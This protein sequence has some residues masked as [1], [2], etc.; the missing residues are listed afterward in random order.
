MRLHRLAILALLGLLA[1]CVDDVATGGPTLT[2]NDVSSDGSNGGAVGDAAGG[3]DGTGADDLGSGGDSVEPAD[4]AIGSDT[5]TGSGD[6]IEDDA[7]GTPDV[8]DTDT[9]GTP[10]VID[11]DTPG[12]P[13]VVDTDTPGTPDVVDTDTPGTPDVVDNDTP[14]TPDV[15]DNDTPGTPDVIEDDTTGTPDVIEQDS[16]TGG[17]TATDQDADQ[18][19]GTPG[20]V[21]TKPSTEVC[22]GIDNDCNG[23]TDEATCADGSCTTG[24]CSPSK[25]AP[26]GF[27]CVYAPKAGACDDGDACTLGDTCQG[28]ICA[29][30]AAKECDDGNACTADTCG[31]GV[32][33]HVAVPG[34]SGGTCLYGKQQCLKGSFCAM[35]EGVCA[36]EGT[37]AP[38]PVD[39]PKNY[40]PVCGCNGKTYQNSCAASAS[41]VGVASK[42]AC[43]IACAVGDASVCGTTSYCQGACGGKGICEARPTV[44]TKELA[45]VCG[46]DGKTYQNACFAKMAGVAKA[47]DGACAPPGCKS[48]TDCDDGKPCTLD[49]C[50]LATGKC[51]HTAIA[52][53]S[54]SCAQGQSCDDG[55]VCTS[56]TC[57]KLGVCLHGAIDGICDDGNACTHKDYCKGGQCVAGV[58]KAC[59]DGN[60]CT[61]D[62]CDAST[63]LCVYKP[64]AGCTGNKCTIGDNT[65]CTKGAWCEATTVG[66]CS[67]GGVCSTSPTI[68]PLAVVPVCGCDAKTYNNACEAAKAGVNVASQGPCFKPECATNADCNDGD[69][70]T[71]DACSAGKCTHTAIKGCKKCAF[72][73]QCDDGNICTTDACSQGICV[74]ATI[75]GCKACKSGAECS[76]GQNCTYD[77]CVGG[78]C[79]HQQI[80]GCQ[81]TGTCVIGKSGACGPGLWCAGSVALQKC[82]GTGICTA[83]SN[84]TTFSGKVCGCDGKTYDNTCAAAKVDAGI[85]SYGAC[86]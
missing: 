77:S 49:A 5:T 1:A 4:I 15:V 80:P 9:P 65:T 51:Q 50:E 67:G 29:P 37:C 85:E 82:G 45:Q 26:S 70:C 32:C 23:Q 3:S 2:A 38:M 72:A 46:C 59:N 69:A 17:D 60:A 35:K 52:G 7:N 74:W 22:D 21:P 84:C 73:S 19:T 20:C 71:T 76:D 6:A 54:G 12:T 16:A 78:K 43:A 75:Q 55:N 47:S 36:G 25:T 66:T 8:I 11:T 83:T 48:A 41:G 61:A 57:T 31:N 34:C 42:G 39:C 44:C 40:D 62:S 81:S 86:K 24:A 58:G 33:A 68:C 63:G 79:Q 10:D 64:I 18:D 53:C 27:A 28:G 14:G 56:D 30:G 13:D